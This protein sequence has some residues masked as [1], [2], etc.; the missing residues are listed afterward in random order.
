[1]YLHQNIIIVLLLSPMLTI[2]SLSADSFSKQTTLIQSYKLKLRKKI[3]YIQPHNS[4]DIVKLT[5]KQVKPILYTRPVSLKNLSIKEKK[6]NFIAMI[7]PSILVA[8][9]HLK[10]DQIHVGKLILKKRKTKKEL[11]WLQQKRE[12]F[13][14]NDNFEL[15]YKMESH[16]NSIVIAQAIIESGWGTSTL[17]KKA[18]NIFG[19]WSFDSKEQRLATSKKRGKRT[20]YVKKYISMEES[21]YDYFKTL[22]TVPNYAKFREKRVHNKNPYTLIKYLG[23]YSEEGQIYTKKLKNMI[24]ENHLLRYDD[25]HLAL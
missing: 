8:K 24:Q 13:K 2:T 18:N 22:S 3:R 10:C 5:S 6:Q 17:F 21:I 4:K 16:P 23:H 9:Y 7:T 25:Y 11:L 1:M 12:E 15:F 19:V 14:T 20:I